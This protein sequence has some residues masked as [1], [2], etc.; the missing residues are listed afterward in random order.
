MSGVEVW[1]RVGGCVRMYVD[2]VGGVEMWVLL[3][4]WRCVCGGRGCAWVYHE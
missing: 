4:V 2:A 1:R 3:V